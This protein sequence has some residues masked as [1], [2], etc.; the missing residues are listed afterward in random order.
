MTANDPLYQY[1]WHLDNTG[2]TNF[3]SNAGTSTHDINVDGVITAGYTGTGI[4]VAAVDQGLEIAHEDLAGNVVSGGSWDYVQSDND[5]TLIAVD[6]DHG[7]MVSG[8]I[9]SVGWNGKGGRGVAPSA[10]LKGF[11]LIG[12]NIETTANTVSA[13]GGA[14]YAQDV[15]IFNQ[16]YG[17]TP[18]GYSTINSSVSAQYD[19]AVTSLRSNKGAIFVKSSGNAYNYIKIG[20]TW[21]SCDTYY[22]FA[23]GYSCSNSSADPTNALPENIVVGALQA[24]GVKS[25]YSTSGAS[26]W[27]SAPGGEGGT[28]YPAMMTTD[29]SGCSRGAVRSGYTYNVNA[30]NNQG[31]HSENSGCNYTSQMNGTSSAA[32]ITSGAI[33]LILEA[34]PALT[35][36]DVK[37][38][39]ATTSTQVDASKA[40][41]S[42]TINSATWV[43]VPAWTTNDAGHKF[44]DW[45]GFGRIDVGAAI[46]AALAYSAGSL[47]TLNITDY[48]NNASGTLNTTITD[49]NATGITNAIAVSESEIIEAVQIK[50]NINHGFAG[51]IGIELV[52]PAGTR[53]VLWTPYNI[54]FSNNNFTNQIITSNAFYGEET[55]GNWT[56]RVIDGGNEDVGTLV[57]WSIRFYEH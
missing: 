3:A 50:V 17:R 48:A 43:G 38:I 27:V 55:D 52:S 14:S 28:T 31:N 23:T 45:Y 41:I 44:H 47:G 25:S 57:N 35:W 53:S 15:D 46:T 30:F 11:N 6:G 1:Q 9:A 26:L 16:S 37:H 34:N 42:S 51:D 32:P 24:T 29:D 19:S 2:Q 54:W 49:Y 8:L 10:S 5:P 39:L 20:G 21:Y 56:L 7:T 18:Y 4:T 33:A 40:N 13:L 36:R 22:G 12:N